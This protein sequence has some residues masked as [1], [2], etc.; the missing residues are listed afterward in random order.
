V[1]DK[2]GVN[3]LTKKVLDKNYIN[4]SFIKILR[5]VNNVA[6]QKIK[7]FS[8][9]ESPP[10]G[11]QPTSPEGPPPGFQPTSPE[12][13]P[14]PKMLTPHS[15]EES[16]PQNILEVEN[17]KEESTKKTDEDEIERMLESGNPQIFTE[18][19]RILH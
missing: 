17:Q 19:V 8:S 11:F 5:G 18:G 7:S 12:G 15:P 16:P 10:P 1:K 14:P 6:N 4:D 2:Q 13:S 3:K 9:P